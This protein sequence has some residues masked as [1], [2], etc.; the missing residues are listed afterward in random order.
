M[1][2]FG[3]KADMTICEAH[4]RFCGRYWGQSGH[5]LVQCVCLLMTQSGH[6]VG[7]VT[8]VKLGI[9]VNRPGATCSDAVEA[10][11]R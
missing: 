11:N 3:G 8:Y 6:G 9:A 7:I 2:A 5:A 4:V 1:S 10:S